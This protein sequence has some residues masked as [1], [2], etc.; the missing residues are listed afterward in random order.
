M[1]K[2][3]LLL[4]LSLT[5]IECE[6]FSQADTVWPVIKHRNIGDFNIGTNKIR[7]I[8]VTIDR[9]IFKKSQDH[10]W[11]ETDVSITIKDT[12]GS[13]LYKKNYP[14]NQ[15][16]ELDISAN[17][18][19]LNGI[20]I[21]LLVTYTIYPSCGTCGEDVQI[22]G[23]NSLGYL[24]PYTGVIRVLDKISD[25]SYF[26]IKWVKSGDDL[27]SGVPALNYTDCI[28]CKPYLEFMHFTGSCGFNTLGYV[29]VEREGILQ[30]QYS[31]EVVSDKIPLHVGDANYST[32]NEISEEDG[33]DVINLYTKTDTLSPVKIMQLK[34]GMTIKF[35]EGLRYNNNSWIH[36][37][38]AG[39]EG[40]II[41]DDV[42]KLGFPPCG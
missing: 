27:T 38:I 26:N 10:G 31:H 15:D 5:L 8:N 34:K 16:G 39:Y 18:I 6:I 21:V 42:W 41:W 17:T 22:F 7:K 40:Y 1:K 23:F 30:D 32:I 3:I 9:A 14:G 36:L 4:L 29:P 11:N 33:N 37:R 25:D 20:G 24:V 12:N 35:F 2:I 19:S 28:Q 13:I